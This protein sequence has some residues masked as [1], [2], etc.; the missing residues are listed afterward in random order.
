MN[1]KEWLEVGKQS[2][3]FVMAAAGMVLL[4]ALMNWLQGKPLEAEKIIIMLGLWLLM[5]SM[6]LGLSPFAMDSKQKGMEYLLTLPYSR[7]RLLFIKLLPR[8]A[9][10]VLFYFMLVL[11]Y[12]IMGS[13]AFAGGFM[14]FS[15]AYFALFLISFSLSLVHENF[16]VQSLWAGVALCGYMALC[17]FI[18]VLGFGWKFGMPSSWV[19]PR[20]WL[21]LN[22]DVSS[23]LT[24]I[25]V[26]LLMAAPFIASFFLAFKKFD[27]RP[28][29]A[30]N[31]RQLL[32]FAPL[33]LLAF[34]SSLG[35]AY[36]MQKSSAYD[37]SFYYILENRQLLKKGWPG[38]LTLHKENRQRRLDTKRSFMWDWNVFETPGKL[39]LT[40]YD[41]QDNSTAVIRLNLDDLA[42]DTVRR[43]PHNY[44]ANNAFSAFRQ[45]G[46]NLVFLQRSR[47]EAEK[48][49]M[50]PAVP[51]K[52]VRLEL[53][54]IDMNSEK[55]KI[56]SY[57]IPPFP[58][59]YNP[60]IFAHDEIDGRQFWL[61]GNQR[62]NIIRLWEDGQAEVLGFSH[63]MPAYFGHL[64]FSH[65]GKSLVIHRL[66]ASGR[67]TVKEIDGEFQLSV[68][69]QSRMDTGNAR[70][71]Y[72]KRDKRIVRLDLDTLTMDDVGPERGQI[73]FISPGDFFYSEHEAWPSAH[74]K[75]D[76][77]RK[78][79]RL[80]DGKMV[81]LKQLNFR[82]PDFGHVWIDK[83]GIT[84]RENG[85]TRL[86]AFPDL[87]ELKFK[88]LN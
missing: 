30:F 12:N 1:R 19:G 14:A 8:L 46:Q 72:G 23:L 75:P 70:E 6:F 21:N 71:I 65:S 53:V 9:A 61:V 49:G 74:G 2:L 43:I 15:L 67:E 35:V 16:I 56:L 66:P 44:L 68:F 60:V 31:R 88:N 80:Q 22:Y 42:W 33:L 4:V 62:A 34:A 69:F 79:Y 18:C 26:F 48:A 73:F 86:F 50:Q 52:N 25:V 27:L 7:R 38:K 24:A 36:L 17:L 39:F 81:F 58:I 51:L 78:I 64:L 5:F 47:E 55:S 87:G 13:D 10:A 57:Q 54:V 84:L 85:R 59:R 45:Y 20:P 37:E 82:G 40:A 63:K 76:K 11:L 3:Y 77:W 41:V 83:S 32:F 28:A 29:R